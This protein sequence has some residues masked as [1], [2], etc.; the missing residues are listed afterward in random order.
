MITV[1]KTGLAS[2]TSPVMSVDSP[3]VLPANLMPQRL[4]VLPVN[5]ILLPQHLK[6]HHLQ[7]DLLHHLPHKA[8]HRAERCLVHMPGHLH[9]L[10]ERCL[11]GIKTSVIS[12]WLE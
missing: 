10:K 11:S 9:L 2:P 1:I 4:Q 7:A 6:F 3:F 12:S 5:L 8:H